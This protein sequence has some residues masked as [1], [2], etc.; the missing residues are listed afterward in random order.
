[1]AIPKSETESLT[2]TADGKKPSTVQILGNKRIGVG[3]YGA[4]Y[5]ADVAIGNHIRKFAIKKFIPRLGINREEEFA[6]RSI[7]NYQLAKN[8]GLKVFPTYRLG[9]DRKTILMTNGNSDLVICLGSDKGSSLETRGM[10]RIPEDETNSDNYRHLITGLFDQAIIATKHGLSLG[11][12]DVFF[13]LVNIHT[14][15]L[16]FVLGDFDMFNVSSN[17][18]GDNLLDDNLAIVVKSLTE[19]THNNFSPSDA[20]GAS[21]GIELRKFKETHK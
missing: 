4:V 3:D 10:Q 11:H 19:F 12:S 5:E 6:A 20:Y 1:M 9:E 14:S 7:A 2:F 13:Y 17:K 21:V 18:R 8:A 16:D 15:E